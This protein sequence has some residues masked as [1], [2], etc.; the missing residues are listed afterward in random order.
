MRPHLTSSRLVICPW[1]QAWIISARFLRA[2][3]ASLSRALDALG[4]K[5]NDTMSP[6]CGVGGGR[7]GAE[8][9]ASL[10]AQP[11]FSLCSSD[12]QRVWSLLLLLHEWSLSEG[13]HVVGPTRHRVVPRVRAVPGQGGAGSVRNSAPRPPAQHIVDGIVMMDRYLA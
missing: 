9:P 4:D 2:F 6:P 13:G 8:A 11:P 5:K 7:W 1:D 12:S 10:I 3:S